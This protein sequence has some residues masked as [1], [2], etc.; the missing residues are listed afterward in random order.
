MTTWIYGPVPPFIF[1]PAT[2]AAGATA[3]LMT[4]GLI[5]IVMVT[6]SI[7]LV[8]ALWPVSKGVAS[9][10]V[11][12]LFA[13]LL[14]VAIWPGSS[15]QFIQADNIAVAFGLLANLAIARSRADGASIRWLA[16]CLAIVAIGCKQTAI[17]SA[18]AQ[19]LWLGCRE[20]VKGALIHGIRLVVSAL[21]AGLLAVVYFGPI[22]LWFNVIHIPSSLPW[23][24][25]WFSRAWGLAPYLVVH[26]AAPIYI[27]IAARKNI[28]RRD[29]ALLLPALTWFTALP[30]GVASLYKVGGSL[31]SIESLLLFLPP[32]LVV[33]VTTF[34]QA[35]LLRT[36]LAIAVF[37]VFIAR[38]LYTPTLD[39][40]PK[41]GHIRQ[42]EILTSQSREEIWFP[43]NPVISFYSDRKFYHAEDGIFVRF[44]AGEAI[45]VQQARAYLPRKW[46]AM[47]ILQGTS[48][49]GLAEHLIPPNS[50]QQKIGVWT[51]YSWDSER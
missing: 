46:N 32:A 29:S 6:G 39:M 33:F 47:A 21:A 48:D 40:K 25:Q 2:L 35:K 43:W 31:N 27:F 28:W 36:A 14:C 44:V 20:G 17:G 3:A 49:W 24:N 37:G 12:R 30:P 41:T 34:R 1:L 5:N 16:A 4:A 11:D 51:F 38:A 19:L 26:I 22:E 50:K 7:G 45:T 18:F 42:A 13:F 9:E 15:L 23:T 8:C 10:P